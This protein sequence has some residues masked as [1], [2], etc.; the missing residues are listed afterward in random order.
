MPHRRRRTQRTILPL[1]RIILLAAGGI[2]LALTAYFLPNLTNL[3]TVRLGQSTLQLP[4]VKHTLQSGQL[5]FDNNTGLCPGVHGQAN[6]VRVETLG[7]VASQDTGTSKILWLCNG[8]TPAGPISFS[9]DNTEPCAPLPQMLGHLEGSPQKALIPLWLCQDG[10]SLGR[11]AIECV[12]GTQGTEPLGYL[13]PAQPSASPTTLSQISPTLRRPELV[14]LAEAA[15]PALIRHRLSNGTYCYRDATFCRQYAKAHTGTEAL[16]QVETLGYLAPAPST[17]AR[18]LWGCGIYLANT[19]KGFRV[20]F[21]SRECY[22]QGTYSQPVPL[23]FLETKRTPAKAYLPIYKFTNPAGD[24]RLARGVTSGEGYTLVSNDPFGYVDPRQPKPETPDTP[25]SPAP[26][27]V[28]TPTTPPAIPALVSFYEYREIV[29][30]LE[31]DPTADLLPMWVCPFGAGNLLNLTT[32]ESDRASVEE[33]CRARGARAPIFLGYLMFTPS[34]RGEYTIPLVTCTND[35]DTVAIM[36]S[37]GATCP[38]PYR[39]GGILGFAKPSAIP[40]ASPRASTPPVDDTPAV[41]GLRRI[42]QALAQGCAD[43]TG[44]WCT[45]HEEYDDHCGPLPEA[46]GHP[47]QTPTPQVSTPPRATPGPPSVDLK[48]NGAD[49]PPVFHITSPSATYRLSWTSANVTSCRAAGDWEGNKARSGSENRN[50]NTDGTTDTKEYM[51]ICTGT[52]GKNVR[53]T[54]T[55]ETEVGI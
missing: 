14:V 30:L 31:Q 50:P 28:A 13:Y 19:W 21:D 55:V 39:T 43:G 37:G 15:A 34:P 17:T 36:Y 4:L 24:V 47:Q 16:S 25:G 41:D 54:I 26:S 18:R 11:S 6:I 8:Y 29:R 3:L 22:D 12:G 48:L 5:C 33:L 10:R 49:S 23:G 44:V 42:C 1:L 51:I 20:T 40:V 32:A 53:D 9:V 35:L 2:G 46:P 52:D 7:T 27:P 38:A 45:L